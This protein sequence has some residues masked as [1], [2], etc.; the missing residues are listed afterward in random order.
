VIRGPKIAQ[1]NTVHELYWAVGDGGDQWDENLQ[2]QDPTTLHGSIV[3]IS[4]DSK[5][6]TQYG[7]PNGN[8]FKNGG[9]LR[10]PASLAR[11]CFRYSSTVRT[12]WITAAWIYLSLLSWV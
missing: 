9:V 3:R 4:L 10:S 11:S 7:I 8:P 1:A 5:M 12:P 6:D 2:G